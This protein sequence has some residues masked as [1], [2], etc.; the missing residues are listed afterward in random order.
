MHASKWQQTVIDTALPVISPVGL[1]RLLYDGQADPAGSDTE[2]NVTT[3]EPLSFTEKSS[4]Y[5]LHR[6][7]E[8][9]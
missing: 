8:A 7:E 9:G 1:P 3:E 6:D 2:R 5:E 4:S